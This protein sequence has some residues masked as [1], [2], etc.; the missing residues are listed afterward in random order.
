MSSG[1]VIC[2]RRLPPAAP[3]IWAAVVLAIGVGLWWYFTRGLPY[4]DEAA[5]A[6]GR[7]ALAVSIVISGLMVISAT[8]KLWF[9]HL[10]HRRDVQRD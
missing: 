2:Y 4:A 6:R 1:H 3:F 5:P 7:L 10:W 9:R 8:S